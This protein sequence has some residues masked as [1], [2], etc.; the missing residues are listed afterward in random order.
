[1]PRDP[2]KVYVDL[3]RCAYYFFNNQLEARWTVNRKKNELTRWFDS[4]SLGRNNFFVN[5]FLAFKHVIYLVSAYS[6]NQV[7]Q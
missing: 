4:Q 1:M 5:R 7:S 3:S 6:G 2:L